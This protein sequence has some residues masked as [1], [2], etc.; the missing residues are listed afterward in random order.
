MVIDYIGLTPFWNSPT[1]HWPSDGV[2]STSTF[3]YTYPE[4]KGAPVGNPSALDAHITG[5]VDRL[6]GNSA[7]GLESHIQTNAKAPQLFG[8]ASV[9]EGAVGSIAGITTNALAVPTSSSVPS[10]SAPAA[11]SDVPTA[12][13]YWT[14]R[15]RC[16]LSK[17][18]SSFSVLLFLGDVPEDSTAW[19]SSPSFIGAS[20]VFVNTVAEKC[21][22]CSQHADQILESFVDLNTAILKHSELGSLKEED[23][24][25]Y[26]QKNLSWKVKKVRI[27]AVCSKIIS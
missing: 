26:L 7:L 27:A 24:A 3:N 1:S 18:E 14:A 20:D 13:P 6:Y 23:V 16:S 10:P 5:I 19:T 15:I 2:R 25:P 11:S 9:F 4:F 21:A 17:V 12:I 22:N 8:A